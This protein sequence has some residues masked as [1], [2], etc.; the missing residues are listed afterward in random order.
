MGFFLCVCVK[1]LGLDR[2][3][4]GGLGGAFTSDG[5]EIASR[6]ESAEGYGRGVLGLIMFVKGEGG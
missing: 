4:S 3:G 5:K 6:M 2:V 1:G